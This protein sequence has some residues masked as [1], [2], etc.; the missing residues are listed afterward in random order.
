MFHTR[1]IPFNNEFKSLFDNK[2][3]IGH[4][5]VIMNHVN[6]WI[7]VPRDSIW[8]IGCHSPTSLLQTRITN[9]SQENKWNNTDFVFYSFYYEIILYGGHLNKYWPVVD[10]LNV[11]NGLNIHCYGMYEDVQSIS[12]WFEPVCWDDSSIT[13]RIRV[14]GTPFS[15]SKWAIFLANCFE[16]LCASRW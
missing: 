11:E 10:I 2:W 5:K 6:D 4:S 9:K 14:C 8:E 16:K 1:F 3:F 7:F 15:P 12:T 13:F